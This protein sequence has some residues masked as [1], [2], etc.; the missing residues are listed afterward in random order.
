MRE[1]AATP[2]G[3]GPIFSPRHVLG[4]GGALALAGLLLGFG[5]G[6][7]VLPR[8]ATDLFQIIAQSQYRNYMASTN[9]AADGKE[10]FLVWLEAE[11]SAQASLQQFLRHRAEWEVRDSSLP[12]WVVIRVPQGLLKAKDTLAAQDFARAV[13]KNRGVWLCH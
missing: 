2:T 13:L 10:E 9:V 7:G 11:D 5:I 1:P 4:R 6:T 12:G 8:A 3:P